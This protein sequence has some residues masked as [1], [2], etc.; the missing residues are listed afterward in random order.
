ME[1]VACQSI[2]ENSAPPAKDPDLPS[3]PPARVGRIQRGAAQGKTSGLYL[4]LVSL[5]GGL[6]SWYFCLKQI[7]W[8]LLQW[9]HISLE[10][11]I[12]VFF[13]WVQNVLLVSMMLLL[14]AWK[15]HSGA[16]QHGWRTLLWDLTSQ[17]QHAWDQSLLRACCCNLRSFV[18]RAAL[19]P[20]QC[21]TWMTYYL[22]RALEVIFV[23]ALMMAGE[24][25]EE[26]ALV[27]AFSESLSV[28]IL[29]CEEQDSSSGQ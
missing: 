23:Q 11:A 25:K 21:V 29:Q 26:E 10:L 17:L 12:D 20:I 27:E 19:A 9:I 14:L 18:E 24:E 5:R 16:R 22:V 4:K 13:S 2:L 3:Q 1:P 8:D 7:Q 28:L 15:A 6:M